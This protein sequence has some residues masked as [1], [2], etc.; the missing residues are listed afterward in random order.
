MDFAYSDY[1]AHFAPG[2]GTLDVDSYSESVA[3][4]FRVGQMGFLLPTSEPCE[5][6]QTQNV[7]PIPCVEPW[8]SGLLNVRGNIVPAI[9]LHLLPGFPAVAT[10][11]RYLLAIGKG[12]KTLALWID[13][14]PQMLADL[15]EASMTLPPVP[16]LLQPCVHAA[17]LIQDE[18]WLNAQFGPLFATLGQNRQGAAA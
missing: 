17:Y 2:K 12:E 14:Y 9:D 10:K 7:N 16:A 13:R 11:K 4:A 6:L 8:L 3:V 15:G 1:S 5:V 18:I